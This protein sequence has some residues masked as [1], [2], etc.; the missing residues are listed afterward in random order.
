MTTAPST[1]G[2]DVDALMNEVRARIR[3]RRESG[4]FDAGVQAALDRPLPGGAPIFA[5]DLADP[6]KA[7]PDVLDADRAYDPRSRRRYVGPAITLA[8]P[9]RTIAFDSG[10]TSSMPLRPT[11]SSG[12]YPRMRSLDALI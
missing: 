6:L 7:L 3:Q 1:T 5:D 8:N 9:C 2:V 12:L 11:N 10:S 4:R